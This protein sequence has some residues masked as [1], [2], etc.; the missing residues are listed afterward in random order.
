MGRCLDTVRPRNKFIRAT[1]EVS[2]SIWAIK[3]LVLSHRLTR[4]HSFPNFNIHTTRFF[5]HH[6]NWAPVFPA[7]LLNDFNDNVAIPALDA[8]L[9]T[10]HQDVAELKPSK[11]SVPQACSSCVHHRRIL[12]SYGNNGNAIAA[13]TLLGCYA[14]VPGQSAVATPN[15][16]EAL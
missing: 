13:P 2:P 6:I 14:E 15:A 4:R 12:C 3:K 10:E 5:Q 9:N 7:P 16:T 8:L 11:V 1:E